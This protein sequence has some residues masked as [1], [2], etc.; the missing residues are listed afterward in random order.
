[1][2]SSITMTDPPPVVEPPFETRKTDPSITGIVLAAGIS[3]RF[4]SRNKLL[5]QIDGTPLVRQAV[6]TVRKV[7]PE[8]LVVVGH[9]ATAVRDT[10]TGL[11]VTCV[12]NPEYATGHAS[13]V[14]QGIDN[15]PPSAD[16]ALFH[17]GDMPS[18]Q[19]STIGHLV[20][21]YGAEVGDPVVAAAD[22][23]R[24]NPVLFGRQYFTRLR[25]VTGDTGGRQVIR[26]SDDAVLVETSDPGVH[27]DI[28][29]PADLP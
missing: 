13:S 9:E 15:V 19:P 23:R 26:S 8:V 18:V 10:L 14:Q 7:I 12:E 2:G 27:R 3:S 21:A 29:R 5:T 1:M 25:A 28:D 17:L 20:D 24:G 6:A 22:D 16:G 11:D 4:G